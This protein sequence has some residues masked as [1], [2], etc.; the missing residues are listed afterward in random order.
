MPTS[1]ADAN[2]ERVLSDLCV[3]VIKLT[4]PCGSHDDVG[5]V[6]I[7]AHMTGRISELPAREHRIARSAAKNARSNS[8]MVA[9]T[10][11]PSGDPTSAT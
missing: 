11:R 9:Q 10:L 8:L 3:T 1:Q 6:H 5:Y 7:G 2:F 4:L